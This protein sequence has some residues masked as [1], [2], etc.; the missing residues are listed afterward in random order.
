MAEMSWIDDM[1][2][3]CDVMKDTTA[4]DCR[5]E[6][7]WWHCIYLCDVVKEMTSLDDG[8]GLDCWH[9]IYKEYGEISYRNDKHMHCTDFKK[10]CHE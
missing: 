10:H 2:Y 1:S 9:G 5:N 3:I 4:V 8:N 7:N 6:F